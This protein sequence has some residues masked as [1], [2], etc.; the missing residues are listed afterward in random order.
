MTSIPDLVGNIMRDQRIRDR[1]ENSMSINSYQLDSCTTKPNYSFMMFQLLA[2]LILSIKQTSDMNEL[3][4]RCRDEYKGNKVEERRIDE[5]KRTYT[6]ETSI[7][8]YTKDCFVYRILNKALRVQDIDVLVALRFFIRDVYQQLTKLQ[9]AQKIDVMEV[10]RGQILPAADLERLKSAIGQILSFHSFLSTSY[11]RDQAMAFVISSPE[12]DK[13]LNV[14]FEI[15]VNQCSSSLVK[16]KPFANVSAFSCI[17]AEDE[18]LFSLDSHFRVKAVNYD[19]ENKIHVVK[20]KLIHDAGEIGIWKQKTFEVL[21]LPVSDGESRELIRHQKYEELYQH[22]INQLS[23]EELLGMIYIVA[24]NGASQ[25]G[26]FDLSLKYL[27]KALNIYRSMYPPNRERI[28]LIQAYICRVCLQKDNLSDVHMPIE[29][30]APYT[31]SVTRRHIDWL[32]EDDDR[33]STALYDL[34]DRESNYHPASFD[35]GDRNRLFRPIIGINIHEDELDMIILRYQR[36]L[37]LYAKKL[38]SEDYEW[39][40]S[41]ESELESLLEYRRQRKSQSKS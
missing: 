14:L 1:Y 15:E 34:L 41:L 19:Q 33:I 9:Q 4:Q 28:I 38:R 27:H 37:A 6:P 18:V 31:R 13:F 30:L 16:L 40:W 10:Y 36:I 2:E 12:N 24:G 5:F 35:F 8:W 22:L 7:E 39:Y 29:E 21:S 32:L 11:N 17:P 26:K 3:V 20:L 25:Q 23:N